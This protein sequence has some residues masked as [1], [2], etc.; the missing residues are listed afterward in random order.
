MQHTAVGYLYFQH[1]AH[2]GMLPVFSTCSTH[3]RRLPVLIHAVHSTVGYLYF[4][5]AA[6]TTVGYLYFLN[7]AHTTVGY[8]YFL[9]A[10]HTTVGYLYFLHAAHTPV[11]YLY[12]LHA[13]HT[14][15]CCW[16]VVR[17]WTGNH[18]SAGCGITCQQLQLCPNT[19]DWWTQLI[20]LLGTIKETARWFTQLPT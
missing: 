3:N 14:P 20:N 18:W 2:S 1:A 4:P 5:H 11:G 12:F 10:A 16:P 7:A 17:L 9:H 6:H 13:A 8:L 19:C 15:V